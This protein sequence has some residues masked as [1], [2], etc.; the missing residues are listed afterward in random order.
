MGKLC[1]H[2]TLQDPV[3]KSLLSSNLENMQRTVDLI[4]LAT[5]T[6]SLW[7]VDFLTYVLFLIFNKQ[8]SFIV[9]VA[10]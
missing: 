3:G 5:V 7:L 10:L 1:F 8:F 4:L 9:G 6:S 2:K